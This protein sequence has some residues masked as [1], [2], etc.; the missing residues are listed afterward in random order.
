MVEAQRED[1]AQQKAKLAE[2]TN[3]LQE[4]SMYSVI[5]LALSVTCLML[6]LPHVVLIVA[7]QA[8]QQHK[9]IRLHAVLTCCQPMQL[10]P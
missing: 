5:K 8:A 9:V 10:S 7:N 3:S 4:Q 1:L 6:Q 2:Q